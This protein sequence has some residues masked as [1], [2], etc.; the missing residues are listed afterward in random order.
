M[1]MQ[2]VDLPHMHTGNALVSCVC[3]AVDHLLLGV[4]ESC[5][6]SGVFTSYWFGQHMELPVHSG[7]MCP[8]IKPFSCMYSSRFHTYLFYVIICDCKV[9]CTKPWW[10][11]TLFIIFCLYGNVVKWLN[12][13]LQCR[14]PGLM[15]LF[16]ILLRRQSC[17][18]PSLLQRMMQRAN[19]Q[20][21]T[22]TK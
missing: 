16:Q 19:C 6:W 7:N 12:A 2:T 11:L 10:H 14:A 13:V 4:E 3:D 18:S 17:S 9:Q 8:R 20:G 1:L 5:E 15:S 21:S 22:W